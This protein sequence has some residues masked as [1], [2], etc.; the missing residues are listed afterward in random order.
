MKEI[1][2]FK[3]L[4]IGSKNLSSKILEKDFYLQLPQLKE[5]EQLW[6]QIILKPKI[7]NRQCKD[8]EVHF[9][10]IIRVILLTVDRTKEQ[11]VDEILFTKGKELGFIVLPQAYS[12]F[13]LLKFYQQRVLP[14][15]YIK[16]LGEGAL[17]F[18]T[19]KQVF[20]LLNVQTSG[21]R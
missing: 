21:L 4:E 9:Q 7:I 5:G 11:E 16:E 13:E 8:K 1:K 2:N 14:L 15:N 19:D 6:W 12:S 17:P 20:A 10:S 18:I 3:A